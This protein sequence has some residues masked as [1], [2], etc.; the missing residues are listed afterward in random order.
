[1]DG[2]HG[3]D[4]GIAHGDNGEDDSKEGEDEEVEKEDKKGWDQGTSESSR[5]YRYMCTCLYVIYQ[6]KCNNRIVSTYLFD[7]KLLSL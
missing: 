3:E 1:M 6:N 5:R 4:Q 2:E 7:K